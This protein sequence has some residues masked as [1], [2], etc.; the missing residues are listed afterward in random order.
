MIRRFSEIDLRGKP[1]FIRVDFNVPLTS[2][3]KV[4]DDTRIRAALPTIKEAIDKG[5]RVVLA[6]H[7]GRPKAG[8]DPELSLEPVAAALA[9]LLGKDVTFADD[10]VGDGV[11]KNIQ[12]LREGDVLLLENLRFH[13]GEEKNDEAFARAL[14]DRIEVYVNDAFGAAHRAHAST[15]GMVRFVREKAAGHLMIREVEVLRG[16][17]EEP[18]RP[19]VVVMGG[20][21]VSDKVAVMDSLIRRADAILVGGAMAYTLLAA[22]GVKV[23]K[24]R[25][26]Q[27]KIPVAERII[28][29]A[30]ARN[31]ALLLPEDHVIAAAFDE[32]ARPEVWREIPEYGI[33]LDIGPATREAY[34]NRILGA[35]TVFW[36]GPMGVFEWPSFAAGTLAVAQAVADAKAVTVV[37]GGDSVAAIQAAGLAGKVTHISTGGGASL[38]LLEGKIL[39]G[40]AALE[41]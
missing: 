12:D 24:S 22:R 40:V 35:K 30:A 31:V 4:A 3:R 39:P 18:A 34:V 8:P 23:G 41:E 2:D 27:D 16:L 15:V 17:L 36:N 37:G 10:C 19:F 5:A 33:G 32:H 38:E 11:R 13:P 28:K 9:E 26:E 1:T 20:A 25:V 7:L 6:S 29:A 21:K 14:A